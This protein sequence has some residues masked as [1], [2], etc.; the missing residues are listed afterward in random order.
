MTWY[1]ACVLLEGV[2]ELTPRPDS[3]WQEI[4][5]LLEGDDE[6]EVRTRAEELG[7]DKEHEYQVDQPTRHR[8]RWVFR[9]LERI[10][11]IEG[12]SLLDG[13]EVFSRFLRAS[14]VS[15][16]LEPMEDS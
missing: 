16:L 3:I 5:V 11:V 10:C 8:L 14:E 12:E 15:S 6:A 13:T 7:R 2:H 9:R 4:I 1:A